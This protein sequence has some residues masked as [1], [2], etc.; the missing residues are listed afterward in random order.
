VATIDLEKEVFHVDHQQAAL[1]RIQRELGARVTAHGYSEENV[2]TLE[3]N[4]PAWPLARIK[5]DYGLENYRAYHARAAAIQNKHR[6]APSA[7]G[8]MNLSA[9]SR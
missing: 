8:T 5:A 9:G 6:A 7:L 3:S 1:L 2:F 4:D